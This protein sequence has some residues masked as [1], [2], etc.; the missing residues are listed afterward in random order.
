MTKFLQLLVGGVALGSIYALVTLGFV[1]IYRASGLINFAEG[2]F[3]LLGGYFVFNLHVTWGLDFY[4]SLVIAVIAVAFVGVVIERVILRYMIG[5]PVYALIMITIGLF[6]FIQQLVATIWP[7][8][9]NPID[10]PWGQ[11]TVHVGDVVILVRNIWTLG[12]AVVAFLAFFLF[13]RYT[14]YGV[15]MRAT[16]LDQEAA[17]AQGISVSRIFAL[18]WAISGAV[19]AIAGV[20][21][22]AEPSGAR[23][24]IS[25]IALTAFPA[26][27]LG[28]LES[29]GGA[30]I[31]GLVIGIA[32]TMT[33]GYLTQDF[34]GSGFD[35]VMPYLVMVLVLL[36]RP[37]GLF[38]SREVQR[39]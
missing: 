38:G 21:L 20:L 23:G 16:A 30:V 8:E 4:L 37:Y 26:L 5:K 11:K 15:G 31:G 39:V 22:A 1:V 7:G 17:A 35:Q 19:A 24:S 36:I 33:A 34:L 3:A 25:L 12:F 9:S 18:S 14:K 27:I 29:P 10:S 2:S 32:Q 28:G 6:I 13:F